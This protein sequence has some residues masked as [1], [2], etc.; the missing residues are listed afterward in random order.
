M[1]PGAAVLLAGRDGSGQ[2]SIYQLFLGPRLGPKGRPQAAS[3]EGIVELQ[4]RRR[5]DG[6]LVARAE[7]ISHV[8]LDTNRAA[9]VHRRRPAASYSTTNRSWFSHVTTGMGACAQE[10]WPERA[11][12]S[13]LALPAPPA[14]HRYFRTAAVRR[15]VGWT[16][17][18]TGVKDGY[19]LSVSSQ[20]DQVE[21]LV[22]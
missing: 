11:T 19:D 8:P 13:L 1:H 7:S 2:S 9:V 17:R 16:L 18:E 4:E 20:A 14:T 21:L 6:R 12:W 10:S 22:A 5:G 15:A 3:C